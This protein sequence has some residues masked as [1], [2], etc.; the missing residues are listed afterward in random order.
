MQSELF[1]GTG[2]ALITPFDNSGN[3]DYPSL[4]SLL[5]YIID[6]GINFI[7]MQGTTGEPSTLTPQERQQLRKFVVEYVNNRVPIMYGIGG[8]NTAAII[9]EIKNTD[10]KGIDAILSISPYYT[11]PNQRGIYEHFKAIAA[12]SPLP[13]VLYNVPGRTARNVDAQT[14]V[15]LAKDCPNIIAV[16]EASGNMAQIMNIINNKPDSLALISGDDALTLPMYSLGATGVIS[17]IANVLPKEFSTMVNLC[18][19]GD[20]K[21]AAKIHFKLLDLMNA[22]FEDG[23]PAGAKAALAH[24]G[25]IKENLRLPL[26]PVC[27]SVRAKIITSITNARK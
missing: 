14:V 12:A 25:I 23:S 27:E 22:L 1:N 9:D 7:A 10:L 5:D 8:N 26:V 16:K 24:L 19:K 18:A 20:F 3:I 11:K 4:Q 13:I 17:V 6:G 2:V 15:Q 21:A